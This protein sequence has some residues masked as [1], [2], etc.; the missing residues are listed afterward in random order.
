MATSSFWGPQDLDQCPAHSNAPMHLLPGLEV[1]A[2]RLASH[3]WLRKP[4]PS[5]LL[6]CGK[7]MGL[8]IVPQTL[9]ALCVEEFDFENLGKKKLP[10]SIASRE[11]LRQSI[12]LGVRV[13]P[14]W[15]SV[16]SLCKT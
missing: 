1:Q 15:A 4:H 10:C 2:K 16:S 7:G 14:L 12:D 3:P 9:L 8:R 5:V 11:A 13:L 6:V